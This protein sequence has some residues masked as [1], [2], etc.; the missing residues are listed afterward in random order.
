MHIGTA[1]CR[2]AAYDSG[3]YAWRLRR[4]RLANLLNHIGCDVWA[5][6]EASRAM[7]N[8]METIMPEYTFHRVPGQN[9]VLVYRTALTVTDRR[10][11]VVSP[12]SAIPMLTVDGYNI[13]CIHGS[14]LG[15][16][17]RAV[18][19][20]AL[21]LHLRGISN[22]ICAGDWN[23]PNPQI[24]GLVNTKNTQD[25]ANENA[26]SFHGWRKQK[27][28]GRWIDN[29]LVSPNLITDDLGLILTSYDDETDHNIL[30]VDVG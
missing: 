7:T 22:V 8:Y 29:I 3:K 25:G 5:L 9:K 11:L 26:N 20:T 16:G 1:N 14:Y 21:E 17:Q 2:N 18:E 4:A 28:G 12:T 19:K 27:Y 30:T 15:A 6:Q 10:T 24:A 23:E 13:V